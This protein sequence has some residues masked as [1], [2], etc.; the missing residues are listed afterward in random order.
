MKQ[1]DL[2]ILIGVVMISA[3]ISFVASSK[4]ITT[5]ANREQQ[6]EQVPS[7]STAF[8]K[9]DPTYFNTKAID[10]TKIIQIGNNS[11][12]APFTTPH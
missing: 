9:A 12:S 10:P 4:I 2:A 6:V 8:P 7:I 3:I 5:P 11:N 1:K